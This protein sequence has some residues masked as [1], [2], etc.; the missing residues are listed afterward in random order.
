M[1][2]SIWVIIVLLI[3]LSGCSQNQNDLPADNTAS[4]N[5][6]QFSSELSPDEIKMIEDLLETE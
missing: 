4:N 5:E 6:A 2:K 3:V 1:K